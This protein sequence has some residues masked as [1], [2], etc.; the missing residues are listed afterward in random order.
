MCLFLRASY[1]NPFVTV[2]A[3]KAGVP[4]T[5]FLVRRTFS[6]QFG[7]FLFH[8]EGG[9]VKSRTAMLGHVVEEQTGIKGVERSLISSALSSFENIALPYDESDPRGPHKNLIMIQTG[10][11]PHPMPNYLPINRDMFKTYHDACAN[12]PRVSHDA[13]HSWGRVDALTSV[14]IENLL[15]L[16][17]R[18]PPHCAS[19]PPLTCK[20]KDGLDI[21]LMPSFLSALSHASV[22][23]ALRAGLAF[24]GS[25][26][27]SGLVGGGKGAGAVPLPPP[28]PS[29]APFQPE[30]T[31]NDCDELSLIAE[32]PSRTAGKNVFFRLYISSI[33][34]AHDLDVLR[35]AHITTVVNC[36]SDEMTSDLR[37]IDPLATNPTRARD[38]EITVQQ[39]THGL[40][41]KSL[42]C[43]GGAHQ[44][45]DKD[46][47][48]GWPYPDLVKP[49]H[50]APYRNAGIEYSVCYAQENMSPCQDLT[51]GW[52]AAF[53]LLRDTWREGGSALIHC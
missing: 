30:D 47:R 12:D 6:Q 52:P 29:P 41:P 45:F 35:R 43:C 33:H 14:P 16:A 53:A 38:T 51:V 13:G 18:L 3:T 7:P 50:W 22:Q 2:N 23:A 24:G 15:Q 36:A 42:A 34:T 25:L 48:T 17:A 20:D 39:A 28:P 32:V 11:L 5:V 1:L 10:P 8:N 21:P 46:W 37:L 31:L 44:P 19:P 40:P 4:P 26:P 27:S 49:A 9:G